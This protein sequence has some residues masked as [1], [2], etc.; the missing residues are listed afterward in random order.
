MS[1]IHDL[2]YARYAGERRSPATLWRVILR[3]HLSYSWKTMWRFKMWLGVALITT[4]VAGVVMYL[5]KTE[6]PAGGA[7]GDSA[8]LVGFIF[9]RYAALAVSITVGA[10]VIAR[11]QE[12]GAFTFYFSR[13]VRPH[14]YVLGK[15]T[16]QL[17]LIGVL[18]IAGPLVLALF[19]IGLAADRA[20]RLEQLSMIPRVLAVGGMGTV[21]FAT[22]P[23][24]IS[25]M[26]GRRNLALAIWA[27]YYFVG[28]TVL[29]LIGGHFWLPLAA[30]DPGRA[31]EALTVA[32]FDFPMGDQARHVAP[33]WAALASMGAQ[34][35][36]AAGVVMWRVKRLAEGAVGASS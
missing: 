13:P 14:D 30:I 23:L 36:I 1:V 19:R 9:Y 4:T 26:V 21:T 34:S 15:L 27:A 8:L 11:D 25:A 20:E 2:G 10:A 12:R 32:V 33:A 35:L 7:L 24:A 6:L 31:V 17:V 5:Q 3:Q 18:F 16:G 22:L 28:I 29:G